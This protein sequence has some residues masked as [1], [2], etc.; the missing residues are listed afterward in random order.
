MSVGDD[1][2]C[3][4]VLPG[5]AAGPDMQAVFVGH[6]PGTVSREALLADRALAAELTTLGH[7]ERV[8]GW[9]LADDELYALAL[10]IH[11]LAQL[12]LLFPQMQLADA[13]DPEQARHWLPWAVQDYFAA[14]SGRGDG[15]LCW[16]IRVP[17]AEASDDVEAALDAFDA[18]PAAVRHESAGWG[19]VELAC[20]VENAGLLCMPDFERLLLPGRPADVARKRL[21]NASIEFHP[22]SRNLDDDHR[23]RRYSEEMPPAPKDLR[24]VQRIRRIAGRLQAWRPDLQW[25]LALDADAENGQALPRPR[26]DLLAWLNGADAQANPAL[27]Q[28]QFLFPM[29]YGIRRPLSSPGGLV[30]GHVVHRT[31][32]DG[33]WRSVAGTP[34][35]ERLRPWPELD[36]TQRAR[37]R[38]APGLG[39]LYRFGAFLQLDDERLVA[40]AFCDHAGTACRSGELVRFVGWLRRSLRRLGEEMVFTLDGRDPVVAN[41][42]DAFLNGLHRKGALRGVSPQDAFRITRLSNLPELIEYR[43]EIAPSFPVDAL[44]V[45]FSHQ[46]DADAPR[47]Q[48][49]VKASA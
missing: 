16:V 6:C 8:L 10:P 14:G 37:L 17:E 20:S 43:I 13:T 26:P 7:Q 35:S 18:R 36:R 41:M 29:V 11:S 34:L 2:I 39:V 15:R 9:Q 30:C 12:Q 44:V 25:L 33:V 32:R 21:P 5:G 48:W 46:R 31:S 22:C 23:E 42:L 47:T 1:R 24:A 28:V 38:E 19:P 45:T 40:P 49:E 3:F 27:A 4:E